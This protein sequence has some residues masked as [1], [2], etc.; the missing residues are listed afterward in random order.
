M[1]ARL[2]GLFT[3]ECFMKGRP[4]QDEGRDNS[5]DTGLRNY[6][7][8]R[9]TELLEKRAQTAGFKFSSKSLSLKKKR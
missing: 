7:S 2:D 8:Q 6:K 9:S 4:R 1:K 3:R 5:N